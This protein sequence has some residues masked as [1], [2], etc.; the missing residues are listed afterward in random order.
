[1]SIAKEKAYLSVDINSDL[2]QQLEFYKKAY[3]KDKSLTITEKNYMIDDVRKYYNKLKVSQR[4]SEPRECDYCKRLRYDVP[5]C[6][7][8]VRDYLK[9]N[10]GKW[11]SG[12]TEID[13]LIQYC[14]FEISVSSYVIEWIEYEK[15]KNVQY[16]TKGGFGK[17]FTATW[18]DGR[19]AA[20]N[21]KKR[22]LTRFGPHD[23]ILKRLNDSANINDDWYQEAKTHLTFDVIGNYLVRCYGLTRDPET[24][25]Y[26]LV[27]FPYDC[28]LRQY[29]F[30]NSS[31]LS[32]NQ[33]YYIIRRLCYSLH[34]IHKR[35]VVHK[36]LHSGNILFRKRYNEW[37]IKKK[38][39][40]DLL[41]EIALGGLRPEIPENIPFGCVKLIQQCW[42]AKPENRPDASIIFQEIG[43]LHNQR[44]SKIKI[45]IAKVKKFYGK[46][47]SKKKQ[48]PRCRRKRVE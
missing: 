46:I 41:F 11:T 45:I 42:D 34:E 24:F 17:I 23:V 22:L 39:D 40:R 18:I 9:N 31:S 6:E 29:L 3:K 1:M 36:D 38:D 28:D 48:K 16:K 35:D 8:C 33:K 44:R 30:E 20:W 27:L 2:S 47:L 4:L 7:L 19:Y 21:A 25:D 10:F 32:L 37:K 26:M 43:R 13:K 5:K 12:N 15:F 14:Q